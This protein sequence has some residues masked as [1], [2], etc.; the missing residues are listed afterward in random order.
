M[1]PLLVVVQA[2][3]VLRTVNA[4][5]VWNATTAVSVLHRNPAQLRIVLALTIVTAVLD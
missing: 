4:A 1:V 5:P 2:I 3:P